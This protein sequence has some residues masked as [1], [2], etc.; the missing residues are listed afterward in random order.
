MV[1]ADVVTVRSVVVEVRPVDVGPL[2]VD[3][4]LL[5]VLVAPELALEPDVDEVEA[6]DEV[7]PVPELETAPDVVEPIP[8]VKPESSSL[9]D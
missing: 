4:V 8:L 9:V 3:E 5:A 7:E 2:V 1:G 6:L